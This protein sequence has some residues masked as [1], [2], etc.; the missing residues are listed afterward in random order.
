MY[1]YPMTPHDITEQSNITYDRSQQPVLQHNVLYIS[2]DYK[3]L[4]MKYEI[5]PGGKQNNND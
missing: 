4:D 3:T 5:L 2:V 1:D